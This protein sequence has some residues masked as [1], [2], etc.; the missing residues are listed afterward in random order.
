M[1]PSINHVLLAGHLTR[2]PQVKVLATNRTV[3]AFSLAINRR[4]KTAEGEAKEETTFV[5]CEAWGRTAELIGQ[6]LVKG[7]A[8]Y[9]EGRLRLDTWQDKEGQGRQRLKVVAEQVQFL[10]RPKTQD[11]TAG[12]THDGA[13]DGRARDGSDAV[14]P[15]AQPARGAATRRQ[16][17]AATNGDAPPF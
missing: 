6:Y 7:S 12:E 15:A 9:V 5:E 4:Y 3:A 17:V 11:D 13:G 14:S 2:D 1:T 10:S 8:C 16:V